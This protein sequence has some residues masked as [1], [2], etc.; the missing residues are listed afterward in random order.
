MRYRIS[1]LADRDLNRIWDFIARDSPTAADRVEEEIH[2]E[3][4]KL[5][6]SPGIGH[7]R[8][9]VSDPRYRFWSV[10]S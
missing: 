3:I 1:R 7:A 9:D 2:A 6:S 5:A 4:Q 8:A 10:Y